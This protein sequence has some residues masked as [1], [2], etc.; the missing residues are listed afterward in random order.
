MMRSLRILLPVLAAVVAASAVQA[1]VVTISP[2]NLGDWSWLLVKGGPANPRAEF[3]DGG[4]AP[5]EGN[6]FPTGNGAFY[7]QIT[8]NG[9]GEGVPDHVWLGLDR[10]NGQPLE[11]I[12]LNKITKLQYDTYNSGVYTIGFLSNDH[13]RRF[14]RQPFQISLT[15]RCPTTGDRRQFLYRPWGKRGWEHWNLRREWITNDPLTMTSTPNFGREMP[16]PVWYEAWTDT[17]FSSWEEIL[18]YDPGGNRPVYGEWTLVPTSTG[19]N[20]D[21][22]TRG[23]LE[24]K[25]AD[26]SDPRSTGTGKPLNLLVGARGNYS[27]PY[28]GV[29]EAANFFGYVDSLTLGV[30]YGTDEEPNI[31]ETKYDFAS[32][33]PYVPKAVTATV[34]NIGSCWRANPPWNYPYA[35]WAPIIGNQRGFTRRWFGQVLDMTAETNGDWRRQFGPGN[36]PDTGEFFFT[37]W[38]GSYAP[39]SS[40]LTEWWNGLGLVNVR[41]PYQECTDV[42]QD[43]WY[44]YPVV[45][46]D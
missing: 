41:L 24:W 16:A 26:Y 18:Y 23:E 6:P 46:G 31:V 12:P 1:D 13:P 20:P 15:V 11:G 17:T 28:G 19:W 27:A 3:L 10:H 40:A 42:V 14:P 44:T 9:E 2:N 29:Y 22:Y 4:P 30:N 39:V 35:Y 43:D 7:A 25:N 33:D 37:I 45:P 36:D 5:A 38:D 8:Y 34:S 21:P 32:S